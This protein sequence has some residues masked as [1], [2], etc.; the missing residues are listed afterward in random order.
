MITYLNEQLAKAL[1]TIITLGFMKEQYIT[2]D[3]NRRTRFQYDEPEMPPEYF[4]VEQILHDLGIVIDFTR[5]ESSADFPLILGKPPRS[6]EDPALAVARSF[7]MVREYFD[8]LDALSNQLGGEAPVGAYIGGTLECLE[9]EGD[10]TYRYR[11]I[12]PTNMVTYDPRY[13]FRM[14]DEFNR[15]ALEVGKAL[16]VVQEG[17]TRIQPNRNEV[18]YLINDEI[19]DLGPRRPTLF[20]CIHGMIVAMLRFPGNEET[21]IHF[22]FSMGPNTTKVSSCVPCSMFM[23]ANGRPAT[24]THLGRGDFWNFPNQHTDPV[25]HEFLYPNLDEQKAAWAQKIL[26]W[27]YEG[28]DIIVDHG[29]MNNHA[30]IFPRFAEPITNDV[31]EIPQMFLEALTFPGQFTYKIIDTF[32]PYL[33]R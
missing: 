26:E 21:P 3:E 11:I 23:S 22:E 16:S 33:G 5:S 32:A 18:E 30:G 17:W 14:F 1:V 24:S 13:A 19:I 9:R 27:Y 25:T 29:F 12:G 8:E 20:G 10:P 31:T 6:P 28:L 7:P 15:T 4:Q 2:E